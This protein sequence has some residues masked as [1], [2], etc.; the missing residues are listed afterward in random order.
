MKN[1]YAINLQKND[2]SKL[3]LF[4]YIQYFYISIY[5][6]IFF[7]LSIFIL[8]ICNIYQQIYSNKSFYVPFHYYFTQFI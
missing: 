8:I 2:F 3:L 1:I 4:I 6:I 5:Q 7:Y